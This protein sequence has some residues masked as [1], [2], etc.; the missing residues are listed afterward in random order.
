L[1]LGERPPSG[2]GGIVS[3]PSA[4]QM[5]DSDDG[6]IPDIEQEGKTRAK[7]D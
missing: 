4:S 7:L 1:R 3:R 6:E 2:T 5:E